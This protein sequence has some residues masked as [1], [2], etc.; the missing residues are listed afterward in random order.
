ML[1]SLTNSKS[2]TPGKLSTT[3][4]KLDLVSADNQVI[5][6]NYY[7][8]IRSKD[9]KSECHITN[10][11]SLLIFL[12]KFFCNPFTSINSKEQIL[13]FLDHQQKDGKWVKRE[14]DVDGK[15]ITSFN[16]N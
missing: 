8:Y 7:E 13:T 3:L 1:I 10:L 14:K 15:Y 2:P 12:D 9:H 5:L 4:K 16:Q 11:L 6:K